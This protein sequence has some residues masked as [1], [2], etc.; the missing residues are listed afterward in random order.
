M[1]MSGTEEPLLE[2]PELF[3]LDRDERQQRP[4]AELDGDEG[5][6]G[7]D[8]EQT[9]RLHRKTSVT[10]VRRPYLSRRESQ[11]VVRWTDVRVPQLLSVSVVSARIR[12]G[13][14][15]AAWMNP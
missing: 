9:S 4:P 10:V 12:S 1:R 13:T 3:G 2:R 5:K 14:S 15:S 7:D 11:A 8:R 6:D